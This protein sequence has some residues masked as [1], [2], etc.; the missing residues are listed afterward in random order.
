MTAPRHIARYSPDNTASEA[1]GRLRSPSFERNFGPISEGLRPWLDGAGGTVLEIGSGTG[2]HIAHWAGAFAGLRWVPSDI[3]PEHHASIAAWGAIVG[4]ANLAE[5]LFLDA[6][7]DW[8]AQPEVRALGE[9]A[10]VISCNVIH[11]APWA[12]AEGI[13]RGA[14]RVLAPGAALIFYGPFREGGRHTGAGNANFDAGLRA[15]NP[16]WGVR[17]L[18]EVAALAAAAGLGPARITRMPANNLLVA[19]GR[20]T[21]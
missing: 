9:V 1:D 21:R 7:A 19:F 10:A 6:A 2:Q 13:V 20:A 11:I 14:A 8:A 3:H 17:D 18:D 5:P 16:D 15:E 4:C 12:V